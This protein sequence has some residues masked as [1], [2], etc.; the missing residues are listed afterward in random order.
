MITWLKIAFRNL[1]KNKRRS[2]FTILAIGLG[3]ASVNVFG[4]FTAYVFHSLKESVIFGRGIGHISV[5]KSG[6]L[7][8]GRQDPA[9]FL[10]TEAEHRAIESLV[11]EFDEVLIISKQ[12]DITGLASNGEF[13]TV[14]LAI[15]TVPSRLAAIRAQARGVIGEINTKQGAKL[16]DNHPSRLAMSFDL[17]HKLDL[18]LQ[19]DVILSAPTVDGYINALDAQIV[20]LFQAGS[21]FLNDKL[22]VVHLALAQELYD[23]R[24]V[25]RVNILLRD[26]E[27]LHSVFDSLTMKL[28][29]AGFDVEV[30]RW[31]ELS[32]FYRQVRDMFTIL[33]LFLFVIVFAIASMSVINTVN[34]AVL[35]R[36]REIG[37]L[38]A[39][40]ANR[41]K[42]I[43]LFAGESSLLA[44]FGILFGVGLTFLSWLLVFLGEPT[45]VP[46]PFST[47]IPLQVHIV[48]SQLAGSAAVF[49]LLSVVAAYPPTLRALR[50]GIVRALGHS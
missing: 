40:G 9:G 1:L 25:D 18:G 17:A 48:P 43:R 33:F 46:P 31:D 38:R 29:Q 22:I 49:L 24:S 14:F 19:S 10:L 20:N 16:T 26:D 28:Q 37:T 27:D 32:A 44:L 2:C 15:G 35:E 41:R 39:L 42:I 3:Y 34:M 8:K 13:S 45:W 47:R 6:F 36:T 21:E 23:T 11:R 12:L 50:G 4:G 30:F 5:F 7:E